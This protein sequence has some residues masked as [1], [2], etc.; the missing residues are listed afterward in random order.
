MSDFK[1]ALV[2][3]SFALLLARKTRATFYTNQQQ[4]QNQT[5]LARMCF[6]SFGA[7]Y[8]YLLQFRIGSLCFLRLLLSRVITLVLVLRQ[9]SNEDRSN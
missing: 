8:I 1:F 3:F 9:L 7:G 4:N 2:L 6:L 5:Y